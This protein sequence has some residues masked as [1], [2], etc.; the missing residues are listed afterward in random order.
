MLFLCSHKHKHT[1]NTLFQSAEELA[2]P[3]LLCQNPLVVDHL[4]YEFAVLGMNAQ[5]QPYEVPKGLLLEPEPF[6]DANGRLTST[7]KLKRH[8]VQRD[9]RPALTALCDQLDAE[10]RFIEVVDRVLAQGD[11]D[12]SGR[13]SSPAPLRASKRA[14]SR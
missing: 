8:A 11:E 3:R 4:L 14:S 5:L 1:H 2:D 6:T 10:A 7:Q 13:P 12:A 9:Y